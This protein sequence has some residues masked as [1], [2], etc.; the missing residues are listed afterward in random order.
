MKGILRTDP[1][2]SAAV[3]LL[4]AVG[5]C[6]ATAGA[7]GAEMFGYETDNYDVETDVSPVF[8]RLVGEHME[9]IYKEYSA[10]FREYGRVTEQFNVAVFR[11]EEGY[12]KEVPPQVR[13]S[14]GVFVSSKKLLAA[15]CQGR[16]V[17]EVLRT[18]YHEGFHQF[19][20][21][22]V[23]ER[24]PIWLN[25]G[26]A[27]YF[28]EA[29]WNGQGFTTGQVPTLRLHVVQQALR[30]G[31]YIR[32]HELFMLTPEQWLLNVRT[33][34]RRASLHYSQSWSIVHFLVHAQGGRYADMLD[35]FLRG[36]SDGKDQEEAFV[37]SFGADLASFENTWGQ[38]V[39]ALRPSPKFRCRDNMEAIMLLADLLGRE[40]MEFDSVNDLRREV[41]VRR[42][43]RWE[44]TRPT[45]EKTNSDD[46]DEVAAL[47]RCPF[48]RSNGRLSYL[49][50][51]RL[52]TGAPML[53]CDHHPGVIIKAYYERSS[54]RRKV[55]VEEQVRETLDQSLA[56]A[57][58]T[59]SSRME[60]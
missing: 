43:Y 13:G 44:I 6:M 20:Y 40:G 31:S 23:S 38:Y 17:E 35:S 48:D 25:E 4:L 47:F 58:A 29:T 30:D 45:G 27:E 5:L 28:S 8:A 37:A 7:D 59:A 56:Q 1:G 51:K 18:L 12:L 24:C 32:L 22:V 9:T 36:I 3:A 15:H 21:L 41:L 46:R 33:D 42:R 11:T 50:V 52:D 49:L 60:P 39:M 14:T 34:A 2:L 10:R 19:M 57:I 26:I 16:T 54:P 53:I 55:A